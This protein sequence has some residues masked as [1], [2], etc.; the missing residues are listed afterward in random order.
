MNRHIVPSCAIPCLNRCYDS[1]DLM[2]K[3]RIEVY[4][5]L[6]I[7]L[8]MTEVIDSSFFFCKSLFFFLFS[9]LSLKVFSLQPP[10]G[11][12]AMLYP[13][14]HW[15]RCNRAWKKQATGKNSEKKEVDFLKKKNK[16][17]WKNI[18]R[19][20]GMGDFMIANRIVED[21]KHRNLNLK[22]N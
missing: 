6:W 12:Y 14:V 13:H 21:V 11:A 17:N 3:K 22:L 9:L 20:D 16:K 19:R 10:M 15:R 5:T 2:S 4:H 18:R 1:T 7:G 8:Y